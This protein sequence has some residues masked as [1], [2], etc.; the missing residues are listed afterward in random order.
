[1]PRRKTTTQAPSAMKRPKRVTLKW[2]TNGWSVNPPLAACALE[3]LSVVRRRFIAGSDGRPV[4][5]RERVQFWWRTPEGEFRVAPGMGSIAITLLAQRGYKV[6]VSRKSVTKAAI[7]LNRNRKR[8]VQQGVIHP[9]LVKFL[10][11]ELRSQIVI[12]RR[13]VAFDYCRQLALLWPQARMLF[14]L[15]F[16][17]R[18]KSARR[19]LA[20]ILNA[21]VGILE[22]QNFTLM[23]KY[24]VTTNSRPFDRGS[25]RD[26]DVVV[27]LDSRDALPLKVQFTLLVETNSR[28]V[29]L[30]TPREL[31]GLDQFELGALL[32][33]LGP[34]MTAT[35]H[36]E[37]GSPVAVAMLDMHHLSG[38]FD[39]SPQSSC[40]IQNDSDWNNHIVEI[41]R[42]IASEGVA[43][44]ERFSSSGDLILTTIPETP[45]LAVIATDPEHARLLANQLPGWEV[46]T[47]S[48]RTASKSVKDLPRLSIVTAR[49]AQQRALGV[50]VVLQANRDSQ[51]S[52]IR[53]LLD[54]CFSP[55]ST[56]KLLIELALDAN[57]AWKRCAGYLERGW[58]VSGLDVSGLVF[59]DCRVD[60]DS[61]EGISSVVWARDVFQGLE[62]L[63]HLFFRD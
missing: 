37:S 11:G 7:H 56:Q 16:P 19:K 40:P 31:A 30:I 3:V 60:L 26:W 27:F 24:A 36:G 4:E 10:P 1:M 39:R 59:Q 58:D 13:Q 47:T 38:K 17:S 35:C 57:A 49:F 8:L 18:L 42:L 2:A 43:S 62:H 6:K 34:P 22:R 14:V 61:P 25:G 15:R 41:A 44:L 32:A 45:R 5:I 48:H 50:D 33:V 9:A 29:G 12:P 63:H 21:D 28:Y 55:G 52:A 20:L 23:Q 51:N 53:E 46:R 54:P